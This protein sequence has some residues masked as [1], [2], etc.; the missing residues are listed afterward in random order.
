MMKDKNVLMIGTNEI[1]C[2]FGLANLFDKKG[3]RVIQVHSKAMAETYLQEQSFDAILINLEPNGKG[4]VGGIDT[5]SIIINSQ[6]NQNAIC[7][8]VSAVS[9][10]ALLSAKTEKIEDLSIIVGWLTL[11]V[12]HLHAVNLIA[13][14]ISSKN[15]LA[16]KDRLP[17]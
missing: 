1:D 4:G 16:V 11:P 9:A 10:T 14:I 13:D 12:E 3:A 7:F 6:L 17:Q 8:S 5:L 15:N 2:F